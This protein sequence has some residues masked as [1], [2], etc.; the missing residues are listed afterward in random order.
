MN[1]LISL[2]PSTVPANEPEAELFAATQLK[3]AGYD[4]TMRACKSVLLKKHWPSKSKKGTGAGFP[5]I[6]LHISGMQKPVCV[7]E[8]KSPSEPASTAL[9]EAKFYIEGLRKALPNEPGL[10]FIA[11]GFNG[12]NLLL[13]MFTNSGNWVP[14]KYNGAELRDAF[15]IAEYVG[16]GISASGEF[17]AKNGSSTAQDLR[18][19]LPKLKNLY[20]NI[21]TLSSGRTPIDFTVAILTL[22]LI[23]E[24]HPDWG[25]WSEMP[26]FSPGSASLD[27][28]IGERLSTYAKRVTGDVSLNGKY[29]DIFA[30]HEK[31]DTLEIAFAFEEVLNTIPKGLGNFVKL[32][33]LL[34][35]LPPLTGADFDI[36]GE[37]Y[38][39]IGDEATKKK[40]GEFFTGRHIISSVIPILF[41]RT[42]FDTSFSAI[43]SKKIAD[44]S[45]GTG[46]FLTETLRLV[47]RQHSPTSE[48]VKNFAKSAFYGYDISH[49]NASRARVNMYFAGD[50]F[51][52]IKGGFDSLADY[53]LAEFP[54]SGFDLIETNPPY[55][56]SSYGRLEE[57]FLM[58]IV[59][60]LKSG[61]GWALVVLPTGL[62]ENPRAAK[63]R[64]ALLNQAVIT[65]LI[66]L[67]K[68]AFAPYTQQRTAIAVFR[69]RKKALVSA[70][71][72][73]EEL[74]KAAGE[75]TIS[76]FIVDNDGFANS[77]KR[78]P[79]DKR[80]PSGEWL[81]NDLAPWTDGQGLKH[82]SKLYS[83]A[84]KG[85]APTNPVNELGEPLEPKYGVFRVS[86]L[87]QPQRGVAF[88][89]DI[90][91][92][93]DLHSIKLSEWLNRVAAVDAYSKG[94][95]IILPHSFADEIAFLLD[96]QLEVPK[97]SLRPE[98][99]LKDQF[100]TIKKGN[101]GLTEATIY[102]SFDPKG[103]PVYGGGGSR[104]RFRAKRD[105]KRLSG[106]QA[107]IF[108]APAIVVSMDG[109]SGRIQVIETGEF[110]C[111]HHGA[112]LLPKSG[113]DL[114][115]FAQVAEPALKRLASNQGSSA[116][117]T[118]PAL[119]G[120]KLRLLKGDA[121]MKVSAA[122]RLL[123]RLALLTGR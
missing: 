24:Q 92:R 36:F 40:L 94:D 118:K 84:I 114:Y 28:A 58:R 54:P 107:T 55:G 1:P 98:T 51:C 15:P 5:D 99:K 19:L 47:R 49:A 65:D 79:T 2:I 3:A 110:F 101:Q 16:I 121:E 89:P 67:P 32:F 80:S 82:E 83:A 6:L 29:G 46:G 7:W 78:Y 64:F 38:Q 14:I 20:R 48:E 72:S 112:V 42:G 13:A 66:S 90:P 12:T 43:E 120:L 4:L 30:F 56:P 76:M 31:S 52:S 111:N 34:D 102:K 23:V 69:R 108:K 62:L 105:L 22:K 17:T 117:L 53:A 35:Q 85:I 71:G 119:E 91:L 96:H 21:P 86:E 27:H 123:M 100:Q 10:P 115:S 73:W 106:E 11:A 8:N 44:L 88:L 75:E 59:K 113:L 87:A 45:C 116:T 103:L 18:T 9:A 25:T 74:I 122:R 60:A 41:S 95:D 61:S 68:H 26:R 39:A 109:S 93:T 37:V 63:L 57:A 81:H 104:P 33:E 50:G 70:S 77:D 97:S